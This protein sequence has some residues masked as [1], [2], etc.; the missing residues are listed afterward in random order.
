MASASEQ[1]PVPGISFGGLDAAVD[2]LLQQLHALVEA[3]RVALAGGAERREPR[4]AL[5]H[6]PVRM[7]D[8]A[9]GVGIAVLAERGEN[10]RDDA[11]KL[12]FFC[13]CD[14]LL[15]A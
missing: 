1:V 2:Q 11:L 15:R 13:M 14:P 7:I 5:R 8:E 4:A 9:P 3:E 12:P 6:Q 10:R